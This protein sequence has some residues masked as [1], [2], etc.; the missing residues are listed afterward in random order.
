MMF[1]N[2]ERGE[3]R[4]EEFRAGGPYL[5]NLP[6]YSWGL[7][8]ESHL[9]LPWYRDGFAD[10]VKKILPVDVEW[11]EISA[12]TRACVRKSKTP[13]ETF[14][15]LA[16]KGLDNDWISPCGAIRQC[17]I[18]HGLSQVSVEL[19]DERGLK[20]VFLFFEGSRASVLQKWPILEPN[21][22]SLLGI[23]PWLALELLARGQDFDS[24]GN[25]ITVVIAIED[26]SVGIELCEGR[27]R[28]ASRSFRLR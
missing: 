15:I 28:E 22:V 24:T 17:C 14:L 9:Y 2:S 1:L 23:R 11:C 20:P 25:L 27:G 13:I 26:E 4:N 19:A 6:V 10:K 18:S 12:V 16:K 5:C 8:T 21:M 7:N 3:I